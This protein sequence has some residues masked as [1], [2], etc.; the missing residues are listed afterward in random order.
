MYVCMRL[1]EDR[2]TQSNLGKPKIDF[3]VGTRWKSA[4][5]F[6]KFSFLCFKIPIT[7]NTELNVGS[8][9]GNYDFIDLLKL[10]RRI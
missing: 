2:L 10:I 1:W 8:I 6:F 4:I 9:D 7:V 5:N 3:S